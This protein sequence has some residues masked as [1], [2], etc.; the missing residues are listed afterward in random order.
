MPVFFVRTENPP[1]P[2]IYELKTGLHE[3]MLQALGNAL[4]YFHVTQERRTLPPVLKT[5]AP[6]SIVP[7]EPK[8][9][10]TEQVK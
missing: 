3:T 8:K 7:V 4:E 2:S 1:H 6:I 10:A 9:V 5:P